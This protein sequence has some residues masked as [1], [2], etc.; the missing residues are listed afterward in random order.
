MTWLSSCHQAAVISGFDLDGL[1]YMCTS[2]QHYCSLHNPKPA[3]EKQPMNED[4]LKS[5]VLQGIS[6]AIQGVAETKTASLGE[7]LELRSKWVKLEA[8][9]IMEAFTTYAQQEADRKAAEVNDR[10][11]KLLAGVAQGAEKAGMTETAM[12]IR[13]IAKV[14]ERELERALATVRD[15]AVKH[16]DKQ[17]AA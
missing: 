3:A 13:Q 17:E 2:C 15:E 11:Q 10:Y 6:F 1:H 9:R 4:E 14:T 5:T 8:D 12:E 16:L 7:Y